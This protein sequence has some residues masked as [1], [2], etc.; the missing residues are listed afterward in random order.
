M[1]KLYPLEVN[2]LDVLWDYMKKIPQSKE[3]KVETL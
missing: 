2:H 3:A 1:N